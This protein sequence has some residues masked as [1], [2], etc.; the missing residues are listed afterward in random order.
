MRRRSTALAAS[1]L[2]AAGFL[3]AVP[4]GV[5][6]AITPV[7]CGE[8]LTQNTTLPN[9]LHC[10]SG[11]GVILVGNITLNLGGHGIYGANTSNGYSAILTEG[12]DTATITN[13]RLQEWSFGISENT[14]SSDPFTVH[15]AHVTFVHLGTA[16]EAD[17]LTYKVTDSTFEYDDFGANGLNTFGTLTHSSFYQVGTS[18]GLGSSGTVTASYDTFSGPTGASNA[19]V[20]GVKNSE[21]TVDVDHSV[22]RNIKVGVSSYFGG[23]NLTDVAIS[24]SITG[25]DGDYNTIGTLKNVV[26]SYDITGVS[27]HTVSEVNVS[28]ALFAHNTSSLFLDPNNGG[29]PSTMSVKDATFYKNKANGVDLDVAGSSLT[30]V[31]AIDNA[32]HG[33]VVIAGTID[34]GGNVAHGNTL[35]PQCIGIV[36]AP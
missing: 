23:A 31:R 19:T 36:C 22:F 8:T 33:M 11:P 24:G 21:G 9:D 4:A 2:T 26:F 3:V 29:F 18:I 32:G 34:G 15:V 7:V 17:S 30:G 25:Y 6:S 13:G 20:Q 16:I 10:A 12:D 5:A 27:L 28:N 1:A 35:S 14:D